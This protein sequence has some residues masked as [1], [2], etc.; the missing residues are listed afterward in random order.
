MNF[1]Q[2]D[3]H[4]LRAAA[5]FIFVQLLLT[6]ILYY[7]LGYSVWSVLLVFLFSFVLAVLVFKLAMK[8]FLWVK[9]RKVYDSPL[10]ENEPV[11]KREPED[12]DLEKFV[13]QIRDFSENKLHEIEQLHNREDFRKEFLGDISHELKTPLFTA[14]GYLLTVLDDSVKDQKLKKMYLKRAVKSIDRLEAIVKDLDMISKL[15]TGM[16]LHQKPFDLRKTITEVFD[17]LEFEADKKQISLRFG[18]IYD[19]PVMV[20]ADE[21][22]I[23]QVLINLIGNSIHYGRQGGSTV[24]GIQSIDAERFRIDVVDDGIGISRENL[25]R[26]FERFYRADKS[27]SRDHGGSGLG[28]SIVKHILEAHNQKVSVES[29]LEKGTT[30]SFTLNKANR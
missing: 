25:P 21:E 23:E 2:L 27:R 14:Q 12:P 6:A 19:Y 26:L 8:W 16:E 13:N 22:K 28:L 24:I 18:E 15:E 4:A 10:F 11:F 9:L 30:F 17:M 7:F 29:E 5:I 3:R 1:I 20:R